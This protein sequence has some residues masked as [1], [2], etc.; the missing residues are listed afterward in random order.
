MHYNAMPQLYTMNRR[1]F[2]ASLPIITAC[3]SPKRVTAGEEWRQS[4][5]GHYK[6]TSAN[7]ELLSQANAVI[8]TT[9]QGACQVRFI[10]LGGQP[11][12]HQTVE[13]AQRQSAFEWGYSDAGLLV[14][15]AADPTEAAL[16]ARVAKAFNITTAKCYWDERWHQPIEHEQG[17]R[18]YDRF[19]GEIAWG[20]AHGM[21]V[22]GHPLVWTVPKAL[23]TWFQAL[24]PSQ[25]LERLQ[26]HVTSLITQAGPEVTLWDL[27]NEML[28]EPLLT[29]TQTRK[30]PHLEP[31]A[32]WAAFLS[33]LFA[34]ARQANPK[35]RYGL[36]DY[37][38]ERTYRPEVTAATQRKRYV[39]LAKRLTDL[40]TPPDALGTQAHVG[41][42]YTMLEIKT[43]LD[44]LAQA[45]RPVHIT[46][47]WC[48]PNGPEEE[49]Q[50]YLQNVMTLC[51][52]HPAVA[53]FT[54]WPRDTFFE[55]KTN[56]ATPI[57]NLVEKTLT[58]TWRTAPLSA[59]TNA[60]GVVNV[61][62]YFGKHQVVI[63]GKT[64]E[65]DLLKPGQVV[66]Q[67]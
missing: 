20:R 4:N 38:L 67:V 56:Q 29:H 25:Q 49:R 61:Q 51:Y 9:R 36:N 18:I 45:G 57:F 66:V 53:H 62:A 15:D 43:M 10:G 23:P 39:E 30:W 65:F 37:G 22:K 31:V 64:V 46:E 40:G 28:W 6:A 13:V 7:S 26:K 58:Q 42:P 48:M 8:A 3:T 32:D 54:F 1:R 55:R 2:L 33:P 52:G 14:K 50:Q 17:Q 11:M 5:T 24:T 63:N 21:A 47:F 60:D 41:E 16:S 19:K 12:A 35:A 34:A 27:A 44:D 59:Q